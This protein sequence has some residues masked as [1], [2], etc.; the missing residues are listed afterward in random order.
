MFFVFMFALGNPIHA[1]S[2]SRCI[3]TVNISVDGN[4]SDWANV[5]PQMVDRLG[6]NTTPSNPGTDIA[7][8]SIAT[9]VNKDTLYFLLH[10]SGNPSNEQNQSG[11]PLVQYCIAFDDPNIQSTGSWEYDWQI[12]IDSLNNFWIWDLRG[13]NDY[14]DPANK[15]WYDSS[16]NSLTTFTQGS[17][18]EF[19]VPISIINNPDI[20]KMRP[21]LVLRD[22]NDT[23]SDHLHQDVSLS[24]SS[25]LQGTWNFNELISGDGPNQEPGWVYGMFTSGGA[26]NV[27]FS[28]TNHNGQN[29]SGNLYLPMVF[30]ED[31]FVI[32]EGEWSNNLHGVINEEKNLLVMT[33]SELPKNQPK[34]S[35][36]LKRGEVTFN[37]SDIEGT[38]VYHGL[39]SGDAPNQTPGWYHVTFTFNQNGEL[40]SA[41]PITDSMENSGYTPSFPAWDLS[42]DGIITISGLTEFRGVMNDNKN[43]IVAVATMCPG[44]SSGVCGYNLMI[45]VKQGE[46]SFNTA[47]LKGT[48]YHHGLVSGDSPQFIGWFYGTFLV[49]N[50]G[51]AVISTQSSDGNT[52]NRNGNLSI[53][54]DGIVTSTGE[55]SNHGVMN[56]NKNL[57][58]YTMNDGGGGYNLM[59]LV[60]GNGLGYDGIIGDINDDQKIGLEEAIH[61]L[62]VVSGERSE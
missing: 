15:T 10:V 33:Q 32:N 42:S 8:Y 39:I 5:I 41:T 51:N 28:T 50:V 34:L 25:D 23:N 17:V 59:L 40:V 27:D 4:S 38:W 48:W 43:I 53:T 18:I 45:G 52:Y 19:S 54:N 3:P 49:D 9:N 58:I 6:D 62:Q 2:S 20:F 36:M 24:L 35:V 16:E 13:T 11:N 31:G 7:S 22:D 1:I 30:D 37:A 29:D 61:A 55:S 44:E 14:D 56:S 57:I 12:G 47:D 26:G 60:K 21:Y 46:S